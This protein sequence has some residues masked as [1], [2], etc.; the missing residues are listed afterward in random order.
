MLE[1]LAQQ[2]DFP[3]PPLFSFLLWQK[4]KEV[5]TL[6]RE[7]NRVVRAAHARSPDLAPVE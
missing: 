2:E 5:R 6:A 3:L 7:L 4:K 1:K